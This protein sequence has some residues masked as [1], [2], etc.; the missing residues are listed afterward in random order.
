[1]TA[2][3]SRGAR[4]DRVGLP[5]LAVAAGL[6]ERLR[7]PRRTARRLARGRSSHSGSPALRSPST[8]RRRAVASRSTMFRSASVAV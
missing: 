2:T 1:M 7:P 3:A 4:P 6:S 8:K 5:A